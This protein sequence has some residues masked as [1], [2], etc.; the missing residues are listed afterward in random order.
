MDDNL[1]N[2]VICFNVSA[3][4]HG[5]LFVNDGQ[6]GCKYDD[7]GPMTMYQSTYRIR[8]ESS[9]WWHKKQQMM[10]KK[11]QQTG[12][13]FRYGDAWIHSISITQ[14]I[15]LSNQAGYFRPI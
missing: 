12:A 1:T 5:M 8:Q 11:Q 6:H 4:D 3:V 15:C 10:V 14:F 13:C 9:K 7:M 2:M